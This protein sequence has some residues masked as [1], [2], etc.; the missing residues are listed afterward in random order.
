MLLIKK[1]NG[2]MRFCV[3]YRQL[4]KVKIKNKCPFLRID[5]L[6]N[7]LL[8]S[9]VFCKI[10]LQSGYH[11]SHVKLKDIM[12]TTFRMRYGHYEYFVMSFGVSNELGMFME[13]MN[14][15]YILIYICLWLCSS[16]IF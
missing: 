2:S 8:G 6:I 1:K 4:N 14:M 5:N 11:Q 10:D 16:M 15:I 9:S 13:Y 3:E 7:H 12:K